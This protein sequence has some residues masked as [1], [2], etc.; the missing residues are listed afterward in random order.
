MS[1]GYLVH[2]ICIFYFFSYSLKINNDSCCIALSNTIS[3]VLLLYVILFLRNLLILNF[4]LE[5][6]HGL[7]F[8]SSEEQI[9]FELLSKEQLKTEI[10]PFIGIAMMDTKQRLH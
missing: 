7:D 4:Y 2:K 5:L 8:T 6:Q 9:S 1:S 3:Y 10:F